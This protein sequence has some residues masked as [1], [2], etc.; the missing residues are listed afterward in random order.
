MTGLRANAKQIAWYIER[1]G[2]AVTCRAD[3]SQLVVV[4]LGS[5]GHVDYLVPADM[6]DDLNAERDRVY[7][8]LAARRRAARERS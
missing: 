2:G 6:V 4:P 7:G 1:D 5:S 3:G 8:I